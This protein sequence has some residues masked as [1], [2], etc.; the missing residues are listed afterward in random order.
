MGNEL[1]SHSEVTVTTAAVNTYR[2][3]VLCLVLLE[4]LLD[5]LVYLLT[6]TATL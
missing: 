2:A 1:P 5:I 3:L 4:I 6:L